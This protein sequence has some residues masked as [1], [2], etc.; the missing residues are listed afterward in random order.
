MRDNER[1]L[2]GKVVIDVGDDLD[3]HISF[4]RS[5]WSDNLGTRRASKKGVRGEIVF[6]P[7][8]LGEMG[9]ARSE[10]RSGQNT[11]ALGPEED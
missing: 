5:R 11:K 10:V 9:D 2:L 7:S 3:G 6:P 1:P 4:P 8:G